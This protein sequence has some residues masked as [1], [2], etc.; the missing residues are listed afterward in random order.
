MFKRKVKQFI[1][2]HELLRKGDQVLVALSGGADSVALLSVLS[3]LGYPCIAAHCNFHLRDG[4]SDRDEAF[5]REFCQTYSLPLHVRHFDTRTFAKARGLSIEMAARELR[6]EWFEQLRQQTSSQYIAVAHHQDDSVETFLLNLIRGTGIR[7]LQGIRQMNGT[8]VRPL[9]CVNRQEILDYL[10]HIGQAYVTDSTNLLTDYTRNKIRLELLPL[11]E[12]MNPS[13]RQGL[14][15]T[16]SHLNEALQIYNKNID[17]GL[18]RVKDE[19]GINIDLLLREAS[20]QC[21]L[22]EAAAPLGFNASQINDMMEALPKQSGKVFE[23]KGWRIVKDRTHLLIEEIK[24][25]TPPV[26]EQEERLIAP[27][28]VIPQ[29]KDTAC[30]D[31]DKLKG[32]THVRL[33]QPGDWFIPLGMKGR[34]LVSDFLTDRKKSVSQKACQYVLC[35][36]DAIVWVIG[37]RIDNRFKVDERT[38]RVAVFRKKA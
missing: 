16:I 19:Q 28:F 10:Q 2:R 33:C 23:T 18:T 36:G 22:Y 7:G 34:K 11:L 35:S 21:L 24:P 25:D 8:I 30:I 4:E 38:K 6:Y 3:E 29:D 27:G 20:P 12:S 15:Q 13:I 9:L 1:E 14:L 37:E 32:G 17:E 31:A 5:V 26:L